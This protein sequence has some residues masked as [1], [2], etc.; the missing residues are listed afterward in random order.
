MDGAQTSTSA[1]APDALGVDM[2][3]ILRRRLAPAAVAA[4]LGEE[5]GA[6]YYFTVIVVFFVLALVT[7]IFDVSRVSAAKMQMQAAAD[8]A[9]LEMAVWQCRGMNVVMNLNDEIYQTDE[10]VVVLYGIAGAMTGIAKILEATIFLAEVGEVV[11]AAA[12]VIAY[13]AYYVH[14]VVVQVFLVNLRLVYAKG[15]MVLGYLGA[16]NA[17][18]ANGAERIIP[19]IPFDGGGDGDILKKLLGF[20]VDALNKLTGGFVAVGIPTRPSAAIMLPLKEEEADSLPLNIQDPKG[21][22]GAAYMALMVLLDMNTDFEAKDFQYKEKIFRSADEKMFKIPPYIWLVHRS[23]DLGFVSRYFL[24]G[25]EKDYAK[26]PIL[27][28]AIGQAQGGNVTMCADYDHPY[29][30]RHYGVGA[31]AF[32]VPIGSAGIPDSTTQGGITIKFF[33]KDYIEKLFVH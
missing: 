18:A 24:G 16:N 23:S 1:A 17:A 4:R 20:I 14:K 26:I 11:E 28:Y 2:A 10:V 8:A 19:K 29:R 21:V 27:A 6:V 31:D 32:L 3:A 7:V 13:V 22:G 12:A 33:I 25:D 5:R 30:P 9:A 15:T